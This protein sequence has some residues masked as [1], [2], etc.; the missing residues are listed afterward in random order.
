MLFRSLLILACCFISILTKPLWAQV[1]LGYEILDSTLYGAQAKNQLIDYKNHLNIYPPKPKDRWELGVKLG[2]MNISGDVRSLLTP[3]SFGV[4]IRK[5]LGYLISLRGEYNFGV[6]KGRNDFPTFDFAND[7]AYQAYNGNLLTGVWRSYRT[8][9][10][11]LGVQSLWSISNLFFHGIREKF[12]IYAITGGE[13]F[14]YNARV[15]AL[16]TRNNPYQFDQFR[17]GNPPF[18]GSFESNADQA[19]HYALGLSLGLGV[20]YLISQDIN[21]QLENKYTFTNRHDLDGSRF[22]GVNN[23]TF[24][25]DNG[26]NFLT[27]GINF[28]LGDKKR[29]LNPLW[30]LNPLNYLY[31]AVN[32][33]RTVKIPEPKLKDSDLDGVADIFDREPNTPAGV[34]IDAH[35]VTLDTDGD[36]VP[37]YSDEEL[38]TPSFCRPVNAVGV[39]TCPEKPDTCCSN[40]RKFIQ[41]IANSQKGNSVSQNNNF[42]PADSVKISLQLGD[43]KNESG[44]LGKVINLGK[45]LTGTDNITENSRQNPINSQLN[46]SQL[47]PKLAQNQIGAINSGKI[48]PTTQESLE[49]DCANFSAIAELSKKILFEANSANLLPISVLYLEDIYKILQRKPNY[50]LRINPQ[51]MPFEVRQESLKN[52]RSKAILQYLISVGMAENKIESSTNLPNKYPAT[53][54]ELWVNHSPA[55]CQIASGNTCVDTHTSLQIARDPNYLAFSNRISLLTA[56]INYL[57]DSVA[58]SASSGKAIR[59]IVKVLQEYPQYQILINAPYG[60]SENSEAERK[61]LSKRRSDLLADF[62]RKAGIAKN[63]LHTLGLNASQLQGSV[64]LIRAIFPNQDSDNDCVPDLLDECPTLAGTPQGNG[65]PISTSLQD[66]LNLIMRNVYFDFDKSVAQNN[67]LTYLDKLASMLKRYAVNLV[68]VGSTDTIGDAGYNLDLSFARALWIK[69]YLR[70]KGIDE[71][72][73]QALGLGERRN[74][75]GTEAELRRNRRV[76][77]WI[78]D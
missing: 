35:G 27:L 51:V 77:F 49:N 53:L 14:L 43:S 67:S 34:A 73:I 68:V 24:Q 37:D 1:D 57:P 78:K 2:I 71:K 69:Q 4:S 18:D 31:H 28:V 20:Q 46:N 33:P 66:S 26:V 32:S 70:N 8:I 3:A 15:D 61:N 42:T 50:S 54:L 75:K 25:G 65:C 7:R 22:T 5:S 52:K 23:P 39:G 13:L 29:N 16:D 36:G 6:A 58:L 12:H 64:P 40:L 72:R 48:L 41:H 55:K 19:F 76:E 17:A 63:R 45:N 60:E 56:K 11:N 62:L 10:H 74:I 38:I 30:Q 59:G 9:A 21:I 44:N 47:V